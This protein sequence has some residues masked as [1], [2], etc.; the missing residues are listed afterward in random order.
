MFDGE[1]AMP[2]PP[3][4]QALDTLRAVTDRDESTTL[5]EDLLARISTADFDATEAVRGWMADVL[6]G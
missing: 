2:T 6:P 5:D 4:Q 1:S 3:L